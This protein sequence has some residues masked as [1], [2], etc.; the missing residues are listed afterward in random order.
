MFENDLLDK[1]FIYECDLKNF[2][3]EVSQM[4]IFNQMKHQGVPDYIVNHLQS[5]HRNF[6]DFR[7]GINFEAERKSLVL[8]GF[9]QILETNSSFKMNP[10]EL[11]LMK[12]HFGDF[13]GVPQGSPTSPFLSILS[14]KYFLTQRPSV[15]YADDPIFFDDVDFEVQDDPKGGILLN[16]AKSS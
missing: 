2:F 15:S 3:N 7:L 12:V 5:I 8:T 10:R 14:L 9:A 13:H 1:A 11:G 16:T 6:P 4:M